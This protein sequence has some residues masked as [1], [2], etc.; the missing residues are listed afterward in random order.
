MDFVFKKLSLGLSNL[1]FFIEK[2]KVKRQKTK[3]KSEKIKVK[4]E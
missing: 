1:Q 2:I 4:N 3:D